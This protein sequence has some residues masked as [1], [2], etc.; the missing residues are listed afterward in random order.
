MIVGAGESETA[1]ETSPK[2]R[3]ALEAHSGGDFGVVDSFI[4]AAAMNN[5]NLILSRPTESLEAHLMVFSAERSREENH[6]NV[7]S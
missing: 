6:I 1:Y 3:S 7:R 4:K 5:P 2:G